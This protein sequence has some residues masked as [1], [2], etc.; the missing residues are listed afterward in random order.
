MILTTKSLEDHI[1]K[2]ITQVLHPKLEHL[3][4]CKVIYDQKSDS[5]IIRVVHELHIDRLVFNAVDQETL[6][7]DQLLIGCHHVHYDLHL[8]LE[9]LFL[10]VNSAH[11]LCLLLL[12]LLDLVQVV[13]SFLDYLNMRLD[14]LVDLLT[15]DLHGSQICWLVSNEPSGPRL[16]NVGQ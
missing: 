9:A 11:L 14:C 2:R 6:H 3:E 7:K 13:L 4:I 16:P 8:F 1:P 15:V 12:F 5:V 10:R